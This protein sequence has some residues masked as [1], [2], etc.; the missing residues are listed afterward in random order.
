MVQNSAGRPLFLVFMW[1][2]LDTNHPKQCWW[3]WSPPVRQHAHITT[4]LFRF[5]TWRRTLTYWGDHC[6][7]QVLL[8]QWVLVHPKKCLCSIYG[9]NNIHKNAKVLA[10]P[11]KL[12]SII[13]VIHGNCHF[14]FGPELWKG[15]EHQKLWVCKNFI[16]YGLKYI[17]LE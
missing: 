1:I 17:S 11:L 13:T 14:T 7:Q 10:S 15:I 4:C 3:H 9:P 6:H 16:Q 12:S 8:P 2:P 5:V